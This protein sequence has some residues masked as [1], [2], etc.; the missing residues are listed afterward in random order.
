MFR[1]G[2][3][4]VGERNNER[5]RAERAVPQGCQQIA[6]GDAFAALVI[7]DLT[8]H[9]GPGEFSWGDTHDR[10]PAIGPPFAALPACFSRQ[11][12]FSSEM[13]KNP[14]RAMAPD[15]IQSVASNGSVWNRRLKGSR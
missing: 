4:A 15:S 2:G 13:T 5:Q 12:H 8:Q 6:N 3:Q 7:A 10:V 9:L 1:G 14:A 11:N